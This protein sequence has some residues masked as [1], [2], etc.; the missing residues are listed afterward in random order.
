MAGTVEKKSDGG[1]TEQKAP[2]RNPGLKPLEKLIGTWT[3]SGETD[4]ELTFE[5]LDGGF[6]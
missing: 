2:T 1:Q 4:G 6:S 5:W 3:V